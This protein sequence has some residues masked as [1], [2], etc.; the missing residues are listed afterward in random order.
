MVV[1][2]IETLHDVILTRQMMFTNTC[3][4]RRTWHGIRV[5]MG[6]SG[7]HYSLKKLGYYSSH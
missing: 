2:M 1:I 4:L 7:V 3:I 6:G 5:W